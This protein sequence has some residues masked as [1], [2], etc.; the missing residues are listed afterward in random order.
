MT[1]HGPGAPSEVQLDLAAGVRARTEGETTADPGAQVLAKLKLACREEPGGA[2]PVRTVRP[3]CTVPLDVMRDCRRR[4]V[5]YPDPHNWQDAPG[6]LAA[7]WR[8]CAR[9]G[10]WTPKEAKTP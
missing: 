5:P 1:R 6:D 3:T 10:D 8:R 4:G 9:C 2:R 7:R